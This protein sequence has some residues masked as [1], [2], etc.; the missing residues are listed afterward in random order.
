M[1]ALSKY[2]DRLRDYCHSGD[3]VCAVGST[4]VTIPNHLNYFEKHNEEVLAWVVSKATGKSEQS[5]DDSSST[6][7]AAKSAAGPTPTASVITSSTHSGTDSLE[8]AA[9]KQSTT[10]A[11]SS[12]NAFSGSAAFVA[13]VVSVLANTS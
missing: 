1:V 5:S 11:A 7:V 10:G 3:P 6:S 8:T 9:S 12:L 4:P 2:S 13:L